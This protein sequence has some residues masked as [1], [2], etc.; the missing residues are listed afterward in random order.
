M[1]LH[2]D[3]EDSDQT[4]RIWVFAERKGHFVGFVNGAAQMHLQMQ[5]P[6]VSPTLSLLNDTGGYVYTLST[7]ITKLNLETLL[8][9]GLYNS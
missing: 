9:E 3:S 2:A 5:T 4:G 7:N 8:S 6:R 1:F